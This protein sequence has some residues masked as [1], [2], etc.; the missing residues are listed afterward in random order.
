MSSV[1]LLTIGFLALRR[2]ALADLAALLQVNVPCLLLRLCVL[3]VES[4]DGAT[5]L[6]GIFALGIGRE[7]G[8]DGV[9]SSGR[10]ESVWDDSVRF[11]SI[12]L[13]FCP[14]TAYRP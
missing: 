3:Q 11:S 7:G 10:G 4:E 8:G 6:D 13:M 12:Y 14:K 2:W 5:L 9:E 1:P